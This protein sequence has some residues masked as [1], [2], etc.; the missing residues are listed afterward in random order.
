LA[1][2]SQDNT[3]NYPS[4][5]YLE[6]K[7]QRGFPEVQKKLAQDFGLECILLDMCQPVSRLIEILE[8]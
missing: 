6:E 4:R 7:F 1:R 8:K 2:W 5:S 3:R